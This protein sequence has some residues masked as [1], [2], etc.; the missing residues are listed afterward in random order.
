MPYVVVRHK[1][2]D[3]AKWKAVFDEDATD[4]KAGG[5]KGGYLWRNA[6]DPN[7][8]M[9]AFEWDSMDRL[10]AFMQSPKLKE[11]MQQAGVI[12]QPNVYL[13]ELVEKLPV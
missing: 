10:Q 1:V 6:H 5:S 11:K 7:E 3:F 9:I 12:D 2:E 8:V 4:R 13:L